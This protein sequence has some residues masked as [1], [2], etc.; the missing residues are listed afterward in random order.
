MILVKEK[1]SGLCEGRGL[2]LKAPPLELC[3]DN[4]AMIA[5]VGV[6]KFEEEQ[7]SELDVSAVAR[8]PLDPDAPPAIGAGVKA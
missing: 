1:L 3:T 2:K 5:W 4:G 6:E 7:F 8:W